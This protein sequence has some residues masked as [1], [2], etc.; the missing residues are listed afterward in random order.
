MESLY[1]AGGNCCTVNP[2]VK[3]SKLVTILSD[4]LARPASVQRKIIGI[5]LIYISLQ[6]ILAFGTG[7]FARMFSLEQIPAPG[8]LLVTLGLTISRPDTYVA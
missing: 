3:E 5:Y 2:S 7:S 1:T 4:D 8:C 6:P